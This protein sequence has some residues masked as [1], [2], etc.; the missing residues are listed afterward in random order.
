MRLFV[1]YLRLH[2]SVDITTNW[3][4]SLLE[5]PQTLGPWASG[6]SCFWGWL[7]S[8]AGS[9]PDCLRTGASY[10]WGFLFLGLIVSGAVLDLG[11]SSMD[12]SLF[13]GLHKCRVIRFWDLEPP[14]M[15]HSAK[16]TRCVFS[17]L[18]TFPF[19]IK[20]LMAGFSKESFYIYWAENVFAVYFCLLLYGQYWETQ[21]WNSSIH[22]LSSFWQNLENRCWTCVTLTGLF[23]SLSVVTIGK[24][25]HT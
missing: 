25:G 20:C 21:F 9:D 17:T 12:M 7:R 24:F 10:F 22:Q 8:R 2:D 3:D 4:I 11:L 6:A 14:Q 18:I 16:N 15:R 1:L 13:L 5:P 23:F 19:L